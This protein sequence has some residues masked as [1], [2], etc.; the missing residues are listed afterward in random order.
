MNITK[1]IALG[2]NSAIM[3]VGG[4][5]LQKHLD[6]VGYIIAVT[7][8][9][10]IASLAHYCLVKYWVEG[11]QAMTRFYTDLCNTERENS[12]G[13]MDNYNTCV[14]K[15][16]EMQQER[17]DTVLNL[18]ADLA[19]MEKENISI[20]EAL[21]LAAT[22]VVSLAKESRSN[23]ILKATVIN[24]LSGNVTHKELVWL[25]NAYNVELVSE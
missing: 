10:L 13:W 14:Q 7:A 18:S 21:E 9:L 4:S 19:D 22:K 15:I 2:L 8:L 11:E 23:D 12:R 24:L 5:I 3:I 25:K 20:Q 17:D 6:S 1:A 16:R